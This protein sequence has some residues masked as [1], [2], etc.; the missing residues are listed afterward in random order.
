MAFDSHGL[1]ITT[2]CDAAGAALDHALLGY[3]DYRADTAARL[4]KALESDPDMALAHVLK[5]Y[6]LLLANDSA[7]IAPARAALAEARRHA[8]A[9][10]A[11][12]RAHMDALEV[13]SKGDTLAAI[14]VWDDILRVHPH[15]VLALRLGYFANFWLGRPQAMA[16]S[17]ERVLPAWR[18]GLPGYGTVLASLCFAHEECGNYATA[19]A[20]GREAIDI[21]PGNLW[22]AH[23]VAH[24]LEMQGRCEDGIAWL[25][26]L[27]PHWAGGNNLTHHLWWH[28]SL[29][30]LEQRDF[31]KVLELYDTRFRDLAAP[32]TVATP[33]AYND[34]QN[35]ASMLFRLERHGI[36][37]GDRWGEIADKA[38]HHIGNVMSP[39]TYLHWVMAA[40]A[41]QRWTLA[42]QLVE[43]IRSYAASCHPSQRHRLEACALPI[44]QAILA[45]G[46]GTWREALET[47]RPALAHTQHLGGSHAQRDLFDQL[48]LDIALKA[49]STADVRFLLDRVGRLL[50]VQDRIGYAEAARTLPH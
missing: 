46:R 4:A 5:G 3:M 20:A 7:K 44:A 21:D 8:G 6:L 33:D 29:Y 28:R 42:D 16:D 48:Y 38:V 43:G 34:I 11:R 49:G 22:A 10:T 47:M 37:V 31:A 19:E 36:D 45:R 14:A 1:T 12:E 27:A 50:P 9:V 23:G 39:F 25:E 30:H 2:A 13:W 18:P 41:T 40:T 24:V 17:V 26:R 32:L 15:D 35:A